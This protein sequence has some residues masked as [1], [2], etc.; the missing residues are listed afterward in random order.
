MREALAKHWPEYLMEAGCLGTFMVSACLFGALLGHPESPVM[1]YVQDPFLLRALTGLAMGATAVGIIYSRWGQQSGAHMNPSVTLTFYRLGKTKGW[2]ALF[3][4]VFQFLG[5]L[6]GVLMAVL[7]A[8]KAVMHPSVRYVAT[9]PGPGGPWGAF[10]A[11]A[12]ISFGLMTMVLAAT[13]TPRLA[14]YTGFFAG[15]MVATY[16]T[17]EAPISGMSMNPA[18]TFGS[19]VWAGEWSTLWIYFL[20]PP[21]GMLLASQTFLWA[22]GARAVGCAKFYHDNPTRCIFCGKAEQ[23]ATADSRR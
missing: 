21:L 12:A 7:I 2:D 3:Y 15:A 9:L 11:E 19:A 6:G 17:F 5:G 16:I 10:A 1:N 23:K 14:R 18:R 20:A 4:A 22:R 13:N 8:G